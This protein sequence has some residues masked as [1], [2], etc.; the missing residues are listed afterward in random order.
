M[1]KL[2]TNIVTFAVSAIN[3]ILKTVNVGLVKDIGIERED[4]QDS[5]IMKFIF[6]STLINSGIILLLVNA[7]FIYS[8]I[9]FIPIRNIYSDI[10]ADWYGDIGWT[11][12]QSMIVMAGMPIALFGG[13]YGMKVTFRLMDGGFYFFKK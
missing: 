6:A 12:T 11:I 8:P 4:R 13:Y 10:N 9:A 1:A 2:L 7:N 5:I 3:Y